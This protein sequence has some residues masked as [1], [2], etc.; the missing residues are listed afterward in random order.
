[1]SLKL[2]FKYA[3]WYIW[4]KLKY[5]IAYTF[6]FIGI[7]YIF[8]A[9]EEVVIDYF[10]IRYLIEIAVPWK[11]AVGLICVFIAIW[12]GMSQAKLKSMAEP[13]R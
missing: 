10:N 7:F 8:E 9:I 4:F 5:A 12:L 13:V 2:K 1:M 3:M 6:A 11:I